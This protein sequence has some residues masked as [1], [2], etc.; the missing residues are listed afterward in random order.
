MEGLR[1]TARARALSLW[2]PGG[3][4]GSKRLVGRYP[5]NGLSYLT[6]YSS[7]WR[8]LRLILLR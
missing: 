4:I 6:W 8:V 7:A 5:E 2:P 3:L 1:P